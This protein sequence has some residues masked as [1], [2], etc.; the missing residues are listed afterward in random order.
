VVCNNYRMGDKGKVS[1][2][3]TFTVQRKVVPFRPGRNY[4]SKQPRRYGVQN[5]VVVGKPGE[6]IDCDEYGRV[7]VQ[8]PWDRVGQ[9]D[10]RSSCR[11]RVASTWAGSNF[12]AI[13]VPRIGQE[14]LVQ[15]I[16]GNPDMPIIVGSVYNQANMPPWD[17]P[18][19]KTQSGILSRSTDKGNYSHANAIRFEDKKGAEQ[20]WL[21]AEKDQ[22]TEVENDET[23]WVGNDRTKTIDR[24]E[25]SHIKHNRTETV[26]NDENITIHNNRTER[27]DNNETI[28]IGANRTE[29]VGQNESLTVGANRS[30]TIGAN[31]DET[32]GANMSLKVAV[33]KNEMVGAAST[34]TVGGAYALTVGAAMN[35]AVGL[36]Q[37]EEVGLNKTVLVGKTYSTTAGDVYEVTCGKS[38]FTMKKDG[39]IV[40]RGVKLLIEGSG[41]VTIN[42]KDVDVN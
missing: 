5:A 10:H 14:V 16:D 6:E 37:F 36:A 15:W 42:G 9:Y 2:E 18:A 20:L 24:D 23:K 32:I 8:F 7:L 31:H 21:H 38:S 29:D 30:E 4:N 26:D 25:T 35:T 34:V 40:L 41:S 11:V 19:N 12:G 1:Y 13:S 39:T 17:L 3:N 28:S 22:L 33:M 27:V